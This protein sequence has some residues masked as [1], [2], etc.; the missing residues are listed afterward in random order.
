MSA[1]KKNVVPNGHSIPISVG[2]FLQIEF[3]QGLL[4]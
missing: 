1:A 4:E 3:E 2:D